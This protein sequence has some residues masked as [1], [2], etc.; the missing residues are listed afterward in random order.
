MRVAADAVGRQRNRLPHHRTRLLLPR[1]R[2]SEWLH[3]PRGWAGRVTE[4]AN[5]QAVIDAALERLES[6]LRVLS[7]VGIER[8]AWGWDR[9]ESDDL[10][11]YRDA[12]RA[13]VRAIET[14]DEGLRWDE[15]QR[16]LFDEVEGRYALVAWKAEHQRHLPHAHKA[17][18]AAF[19]AALG[20]FAR[21]WIRRE[22]YE[23]LVTAM[24]EALPWLLPERPPEPA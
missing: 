20:L 19:A 14:A 12:E 6:D 1:V 24:A 3:V 21:P 16:R 4:A 23:T 22:L 2:R 17:E 7:G 8:A 18:R 5:R 10:V 15:W 13:A 11:A 9:H